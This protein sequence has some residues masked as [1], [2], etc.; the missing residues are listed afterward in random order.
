MNL[1]FPRLCFIAV[2]LI[3]TMM[4]AVA[5]GDEPGSE[6]ASAS[7]PPPSDE[8]IAQWVADLDSNQYRVREAAT[9]QLVAASAPALDP[10]LAA[11]NSKRPEPADRAVWILRQMS[12]TADIDLRQRV[13]EHLV[14][15][16]SQPQVVDEAK[17]GLA[18]IQHQFAVRAIEQLGGQYLEEGADPKWGQQLPK[19]VVLNDKWRGGDAGLEQLQKLRLVPMV[20]IIGTNVSAAGLARL[21]SVESLRVLQLYGTRLEE[22]DI[23]ELQKKLPD[24]K[25]DYRRGALL[26][27]R[28]M[29]G[30]QSA[31]VQSVQPGTAAAAAGIREHDTIRKLDD[32]PIADFSQL[33]SAVAKHRAGDEIMLQIQRG[34]QMLEVKV[35][36]GKWESQ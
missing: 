34:D 23:A 19:R 3:L 11:A 12:K 13:L 27:V 28:G 16:E 21:A 4:A 24:V 14:Q 18:E 17:A 5:I 1:N 10:L 33:T 15:V 9:Q 7:S 26:G 32:T 25:I 20:T 31:E 30:V 2:P 6:Q 35:T 29:E 22:A 36:L 8:Q